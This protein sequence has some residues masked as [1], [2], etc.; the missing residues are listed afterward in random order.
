[1]CVDPYGIHSIYI[2]HNL[3]ILTPVAKINNTW[4]KKL[5]HS[6]FT[7]RTSLMEDITLVAVPKLENLGSVISVRPKK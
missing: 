3:E 6:K 7:V 2:V 5:Y 1:M 4:R